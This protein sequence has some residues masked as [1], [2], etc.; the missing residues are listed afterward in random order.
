MRKIS[1]DRL[2]S[3]EAIVKGEKQLSKKGG[4]SKKNLDKLQKDT[5]EAIKDKETKG[6]LHK[7]DVG[8]RDTKEERHGSGP[9]S[10][11]QKK[12]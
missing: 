8:R 12:K 3:I 5:I 7:H 9:A 4:D 2:F 10:P 11:K 6:H 1:F